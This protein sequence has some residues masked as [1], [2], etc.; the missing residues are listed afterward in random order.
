MKSILNSNPFDSGTIYVVGHKNPDNDAVC[1]AIGVA[2]LKNTLEDTTKYRPCMIESVTDQTKYV[3]ETYF[4]KPSVKY[5]VKPTI[6]SD[7]YRRV[8]DVMVTTPPVL[9]SDMF[10]KE[11]LE[12][13]AKNELL[14][15]P[16]VKDGKFLGIYSLTSEK[17]TSNLRFNVEHLVGLLIMP[18]DIVE[19]FESYLLS[20][21]LKREVN[22]GSCLVIDTGRDDFLESST[23]IIISAGTDQRLMDIINRCTP[24]ILIAAQRKADPDIDVIKNAESGKVCLI[25][26]KHSIFTTCD[27]LMGTVRID[28]FVDSACT[29]LYQDD[30]VRDVVQTIRQHSYNIPV[31]NDRV[32]LVGTISVKEIVSPVKKTDYT[33]GPQRGKSSC[34][35]TGRL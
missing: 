27:L 21:Y 20:D 15:A 35:R 9:K 24:P 23:D 13:L 33:G 11:S 25:S 22:P 29:V 8:R 7:L 4:Q 18:E 28:R 31:L 19:R 1:S 16:V 12:F 17:Y 2:C 14:S 10:L 26:L 30:L 6:I 3:L 34:P 32:E 5:A